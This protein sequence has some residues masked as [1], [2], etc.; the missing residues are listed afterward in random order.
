MG[1]NE[2]CYIS[3]LSIEILIQTYS[4]TTLRCYYVK[5]ILKNDK[6]NGF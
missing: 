1:E 3:Q 2:F 4:K 6:A 5:K